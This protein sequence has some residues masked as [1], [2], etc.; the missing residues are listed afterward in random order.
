[1]QLK[2]YI[3][4]LNKKYNNIF[5]S[6]VSFNSTKVKKGD[7]FFA[8]K[9][10]KSDGNNFIE[11]AIKKGAK[12]I[13]SEKKFRNNKNALFLFSSNVRKLLAEVSYKVSAD[14][15]KVLLAVTGTNGKSSVAD[16]YYQILNLN[17]K[18]VASIGTLGIRHKDYKKHLIT[19]L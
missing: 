4:N 5:F 12:I 1:M 14:R 13:I 10:D 16:F 6:G 3:P 11:D 19:Q 17:S 18:K 2:D 9:G 7:I 8:I 15:P